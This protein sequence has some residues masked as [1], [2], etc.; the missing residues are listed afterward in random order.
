MLKWPL[1]TNFATFISKNTIILKNPLLLI[2]AAVW[3]LASACSD[4]P[5]FTIEGTVKGAGARNVTITYF[6]DGGLKS[7][8]V[9]ATD[10]RFSFKGSASVPTLAIISVAP[11][12]V[13]VAMAIVKNGDKITVD[14]DVNNPYATTVKGNDDSEVMARWIHDNASTLRSR[15]AAAVNSAVSRFVASNKDKLYA[16]AILSGFFQCE[17]YESTADSLFSLLSPD[18]RPVEMAQGFNI[19]VNSTIG[20]RMNDPLSYLTLYDRCD[21][22]IHV[23]PRKHSVTLLCI[24]EADRHA[25][26]S[27]MPHLRFLSDKYSRKRFI[28]V[29]ISLAPDSAAWRSS[30][31][32]DTVSWPRT[33][34][35]GSVAAAPIRKLNI[36]RTPCFV[37][38]D[39]LGRI[40][41]RGSSVSKARKAVENALSHSGVADTVK[42]LPIPK[43]HVSQDLRSRSSGH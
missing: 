18:A 16:T 9:A 4:S 25:L 21:S 35:A 40:F 28:P 30:L 12:N 7:Q 43:Q 15:N 13:R 33:W 1:L 38:A 39:S 31:G 27:I 20:S 11:D 22:M 14:A 23:N 10:G 17:G 26:D 29:E 5:E 34:A 41:Y 2:L 36:R 32:S 19:V 37:A 42:K 24:T 6:A 3:L 8:T